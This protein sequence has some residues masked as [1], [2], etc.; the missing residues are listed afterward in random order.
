[1]DR[2]KLTDSLELMLLEDGFDFLPI[3]LGTLAGLDADNATLFVVFQVFLGQTTGRVFGV[4][5][6]DR[7]TRT[8]GGNVMGHWL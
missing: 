1:M 3:L 8:A 6:H 5:V 2:T 4:T 7:G